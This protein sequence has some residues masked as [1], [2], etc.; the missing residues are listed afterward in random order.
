MT[1]MYT[2]VVLPQATGAW[3]FQ[4]NVQ[5]GISYAGEIPS[6]ATMN[7]AL[8]PTTWNPLSSNAQDRTIYVV[9]TAGTLTLP[10]AQQE[11]FG[12]AYMQQQQIATL[13]Q[14]WEQAL[15]VVPVTINGTTY[16]IDNSQ[17]RQTGNVNLA[18]SMQAVMAQAPAWTASTSV[19]AGTYCNLD[20]TY[21]YCSTSGKTAT[22]APTPPSAFGTPVTDGTAAWELLGR[23]VWLADGTMQ[24]FTPQEVLSGAMQMEAYIHQQNVTLASLM[25]QVNAATT[26]AAVQ[27]VVW[28]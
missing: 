6:T 18:V 19:T 2:K 4:P 11:C 22:G 20:G 16:Q 7:G 12:L 23:H 5:G 1:T 9:D 28:P 15:A 27:A 3:G 10:E 8:Y 14:A 25:A 24:L 17:A 13:K 21:M 26:V